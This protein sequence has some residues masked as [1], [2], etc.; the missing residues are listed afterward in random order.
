M[1]RDSKMKV[2]G[3]GYTL[4]EIMVA[5]MVFA[6][7]ATI[8]ASAMYNAFDTR[9]RIN[10]K[11]DQINKIQLALAMIE[12]DTVQAIDRSV[13]GNEMHQF[14]PFVGQANY[15]EFTRTGFANPNGIEHRSTLKRVAYLCSGDQL[16]RRTWEVLDSPERHNHQDKIL[17]DKLEKCSFA[18][19]ATNHQI[20]TEWRAYALQQN[21]KNENMPTAIQLTLTLRD[22]GNMSLLFIIPEALYA[23]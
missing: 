2:H 7:L 13:V 15:V 21:Q 12:K 1:N 8:T 11:A 23:F 5:L 18:Y 22:L 6:I 20:F 10:V 16:V 17:L 4:I 9:A 14:P 3:T 19:L